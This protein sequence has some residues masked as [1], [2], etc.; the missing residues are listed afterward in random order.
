V[1]RN[2]LNIFNLTTKSTIIDLTGF[3]EL[4]EWNLYAFQTADYKPRG[5]RSTG[6]LKLCWKGT[7]RS[8]P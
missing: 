6:H 7:E 8:K 4:K 2:K 5:T 1:I 3:I